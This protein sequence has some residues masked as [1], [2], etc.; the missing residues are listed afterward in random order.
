M[1]TFFET[2]ALAYSPE[3][4]WD[5]GMS[6][7]SAIVSNGAD[8]ASLTMYST[9]TAATGPTGVGDDSVDYLNTGYHRRNSLPTNLSTNN[10]GLIVISFKINSLDDPAANQYLLSAGRAIS[11]SQIMSIVVDTSGNLNNR[12][13]ENGSATNSAI[14]VPNTAV[15]VADGTYHFLALRQK[16][17][18]TGFEMYLDG[19]WLAVTNTA[20]GS[21]SINDW[22]GSLDAAIAIDRFNI[23]RSSANSTGDYLTGEVS[24]VAIYTTPLSNAQVDVLYNAWN[25]T[26]TTTN[27][28]NKT[29]RRIGRRIFTDQF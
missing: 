6:G 9:V 2:Q 17:D 16:N 3:L 29:H 23:G 18:N 11:G 10:A 15:N 28:S 4:N 13:A 7:S 27:F 24:H 1:P 19:S 8:T 20:I 5:M 26:P 21:S 22:W 12:W 25:Q 14:T